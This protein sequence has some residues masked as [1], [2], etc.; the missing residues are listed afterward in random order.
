MLERPRALVVGMGIAGLAAA[1][2]LHDI[3]WETVVVE[4]ARER[5]SSGYALG[6]FGTG[7]AAAARLGV[8]EAMGGIHPGR[9]TMYDVE[10]S[11]RRRPGLSLGDGP[12]APSLVMRGDA[13]AALFDGI[14][15]ASH[16]H[17]GAGTISA[18]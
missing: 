17:V 11:G 18:A 1:L 15:D 10:R 3:G 4:R 7:R 13:E 9:A 6:L 8:L 14:A 12:E 2:R 5:R 16:F